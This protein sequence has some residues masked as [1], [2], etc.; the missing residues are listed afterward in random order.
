M[1]KKMDWIMKKAFFTEDN[2][3]DNIFDISICITRVMN[4]WIIKLFY[5][6]YLFRISSKCSL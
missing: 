6:I 1:I 5:K 3:L 4:F 2:K